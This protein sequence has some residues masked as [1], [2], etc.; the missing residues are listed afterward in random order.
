MEPIY[1]IF[2]QLLKSNFAPSH[3]MMYKKLAACASH[4]TRAM[5]NGFDE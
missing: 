5:G 3:G 1:W 4:S 2:K